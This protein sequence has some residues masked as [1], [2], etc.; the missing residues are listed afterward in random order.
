[1]CTLVLYSHVSL[2]FLQVHERMREKTSKDFICT[3]SAIYYHEGVF[4]GPCY[5]MHIILCTILNK[6][7]V[8][9]P[10]DNGG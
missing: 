5:Y 8:F 6:W 3:H 4:I 10:S 7:L 1:M 2:Y 9:I